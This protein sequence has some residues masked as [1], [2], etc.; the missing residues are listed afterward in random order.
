MS[1][2]PDRDQQET[3]AA[4][5]S[6]SAR[7]ADGGAGAIM[8]WL[9]VAAA[10]GVL[11]LAFLARAMWLNGKPDVSAYPKLTEISLV[12]V[13]PSGK[14]ISLADLQGKVVLINFW[15][16]W[17][18][19]CIHEFP[20]LLALEKR[21]RDRDDFLLLLVSCEPPRGTPPKLEVLRTDTKGF[22]DQRFVDVP[23]YLDPDSKTRDALNPAIRFWPTTLLLD[24]DQHIR[25]RWENAQHETTFAGEIDRLLGEK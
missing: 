20:E 22:L 12:P 5:H 2:T 10:V 19:G 13:S 24:R 1:A 16:T 25:A 21:Y 14:T 4:G 17:C 3:Q 8:F 6:S 18:E 11:L 7:S 23:T 9:I 15:G